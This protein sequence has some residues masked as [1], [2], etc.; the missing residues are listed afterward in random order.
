[1]SFSQAPQKPC[2][3][4]GL[5]FDDPN[6]DPFADSAALVSLGSLFLPAD[7][8]C[9]ILHLV[10]VPAGH[11]RRW[12]VGPRT[13]VRLCFAPRGTGSHKPTF[14]VGLAEAPT[15][16]RGLSSWGLQQERPFSSS[17]LYRGR[18]PGFPRV[19]PDKPWLCC[20]RE[21]TAGKGPPRG[22]EVERGANSHTALKQ[23]TVLQFHRILVD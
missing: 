7:L 23:H 21:K 2:T 4:L 15:D 5:Q 1:M 9:P 13:R 20:D 3:H 14:T 17:W 8:V 19:E 18:A 12:R 6:F 11:G 10:C 16:P 22:L